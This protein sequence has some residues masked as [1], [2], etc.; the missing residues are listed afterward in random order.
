MT[1]AD[2]TVR[3]LP[4]E[5]AQRPVEDYFA[6]FRWEPQ[7]MDPASLTAHEYFAILGA[8]DIADS[9]TVAVVPAAEP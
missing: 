7:L 6:T 2:S 9:A 1:G 8:D 5:D 3:G 4:A